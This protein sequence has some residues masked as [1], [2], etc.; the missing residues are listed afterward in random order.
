M[1]KW[2]FSSLVAVFVV[3]T[4]CCFSGSFSWAAD[5]SLA[6]D[7]D[8]GGK[9]ISKEKPR[10]TA[11][12]YFG[13]ISY[14]SAPRL[15]LTVDPIDVRLPRKTFFL[16]EQTK[17]KL[18]DKRAKLEDLRPGDKVAVRY[19]AEENLAVAD[20]IFIVMGEFEPSKYRSK[21]KKKRKGH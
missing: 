14:F 7:G 20:E 6:E 9:K 8:V 16:D 11:G 18:D 10:T 3:I 17:Y 19:F 1:N 2:Y 4:L 13:N 15:V 12:I 5:G 21:E